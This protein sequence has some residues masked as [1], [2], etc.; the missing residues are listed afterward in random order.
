MDCPASA[1]Q[2]AAYRNELV[3]AGCGDLSEESKTENL[4]KSKDAR[5]RKDYA[6][7]VTEI[8]DAIH[9]DGM[10]LETVVEIYD[11]DMVDAALQ[12]DKGMSY[13]D[14]NAK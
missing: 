7:E 1:T 2:V 13:D 8:R 11:A 6:S 9:R 4:L 14:F 5:R 10:S 3:E 12:G